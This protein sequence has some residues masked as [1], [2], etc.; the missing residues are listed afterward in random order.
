MIHTVEYFKI[1]RKERLQHLGYLMSFE[2]W[3]KIQTKMY[4][5][6]SYDWHKNAPPGD[7]C[8]T[9]SPNN[10]MFLV[11][12]YDVYGMINLKFC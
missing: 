2:N 10:S 12:L 5:H 7:E 9:H 6:Y 4:T 11:I 1:P 3:K 8:T